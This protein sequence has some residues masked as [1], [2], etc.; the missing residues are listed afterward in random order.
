M[1]VPFDLSVD[2]KPGPKLSKGGYN[3]LSYS[4]QWITHIVSRLNTSPLPSE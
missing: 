4:L 3:V 1:K 2:K